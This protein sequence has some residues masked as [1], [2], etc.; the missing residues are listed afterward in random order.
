MAT[1]GAVKLRGRFR[2]GTR[3]RLVE[4]QDER[5]LR[6][7]GGREV[8]ATTVD[9]DGV[10]AFDGLKLDKRYF[11]VGHV[12]G[13][14]VEARVRARE[15]ADDAASLV[16]PPVGTDQTRHAGGQLVGHPVERRDTPA[17]AGTWWGQDQVPEGTVQRSDTP[18][19]SAQPIPPVELAQIHGENVKAKSSAAKSGA[20]IVAN[21]S[22]R[23]GDEK[24]S[25]G[26]AKAARTSR[27]RSRKSS[28]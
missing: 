3:V 17:G 27:S 24:S 8:G 18:L 6:A 10:A 28:K 26:T 11:I 13:Q 15:N 20:G 12:D 25:G 2:P 19:G 9:K 1:T 7:E 4:V 5:V 23:T 22:P 21:D 14:P 16:Q